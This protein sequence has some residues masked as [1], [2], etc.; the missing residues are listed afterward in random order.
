MLIVSIPIAQETGPGLLSDR[1]DTVL[2]SAVST[3]PE[4]EKLAVKLTLEWEVKLFLALYLGS[5]H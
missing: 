1:L 5:V 2:D 4:L 3:L